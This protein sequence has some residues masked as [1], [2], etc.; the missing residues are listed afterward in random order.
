MPELDT[1]EQALAYL[2]QI[3]PNRRFRVTPFAMGWVCSPILGAEQ[4]TLSKR[5]GLAKLVID[6]TT[7]VVTQYPS[8]PASRVAQTYTAARR[9]GTPPAGRQI[10][11]PRWRITIQRT[12]ED[13]ATIDY[14]MTAVSLTNPAELNQEHPLTINKRT[15]RHEPRDPLS[16]VAMSQAEW[17][18]RQN[19]G[20]WPEYATTEF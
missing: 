4:N 14:E 18:S 5:V 8:W 13:S 1:P 6:S 9:H 16:N 12:R 15:Y 11:P 20:T 17:S 19:R 7:G 10:Y 3:S 2:A